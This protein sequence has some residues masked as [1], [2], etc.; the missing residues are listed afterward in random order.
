MLRVIYDANNCSDIYQA[1]LL[2]RS[3]ALNELNAMLPILEFVLTTARSVRGTSIL[4]QT[5]PNLPKGER[6]KHL[7]RLNPLTSNPDRVFISLLFM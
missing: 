4:R 5:V 1:L 7:Q 2:V 3:L 6:Q